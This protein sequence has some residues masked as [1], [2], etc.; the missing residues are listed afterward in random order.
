MYLFKEKDKLYQWISCLIP[1]KIYFGPFPN[2]L[3]IDSLIEENFDLI[4]NLTVD[5]EL[6][7]NDNKEEEVIYNIP[8]KKYMHYPI[9]DNDVPECIS[10]YC[11]FINKLK[12]FYYNNKK[13]YIHCRG[14]HG[15]SGL[16][17][18]SLLFSIKKNEKLEDIIKE[19]N[20]S[21]NKR[22][23]IRNKWKKREAP[24]NSKQYLFLLKI[25]KD[26]YISINKNNYYQWLYSKEY[27]YYD[28]LKFSCL[29]D[30]YLCENLEK[31]KKYNLF[32]NYFFEKLKN[33][34][35]ECKFY[36]TYLRRFLITDCDNKEYCYMVNNVL[37]DIRDHMNYE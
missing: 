17:C 20:I 34:E 25:H 19:V 24:F 37:C 22:E 11:K 23:N 31:N 16:T 5:D 12:N 3:L 7:Y 28:N 6:I 18:S 21:H 4:V 14:G 10:T 30:L 9:R 36:L 8:S 2:Q 26:I 1:N 29:F 27:I 13:I 32:Y 35:N 33:K 15:R